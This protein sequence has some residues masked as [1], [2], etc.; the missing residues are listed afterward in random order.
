M[1]LHIV[2]DLVSGGRRARNSA[3]QRRGARFNFTN[4][5][6]VFGTIRFLKNVMG[7][8]ILESCRKEWLGRG[9]DVDYRSLLEEVAAIE[10]RGAVI[11]PDDQRFFNPPV[12]LDAISAQLIETGF[13]DSVDS[14]NPALDCQ[15]YP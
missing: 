12:M 10:G 7:L 14:S 1:G 3:Y 9:L 8:W 4:E 5:G 15:D 11:F 13:G 6:G 2:W